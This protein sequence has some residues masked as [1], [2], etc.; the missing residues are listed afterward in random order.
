MFKIVGV[1]SRKVEAG[2]LQRGIPVIIGVNMQ[3]ESQA[4]NEG[5]VS[6]SSLLCVTY[7]VCVVLT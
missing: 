2:E 7:V 1:F 6:E 3:M 5:N 4:R